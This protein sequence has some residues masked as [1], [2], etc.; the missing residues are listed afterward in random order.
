MSKWMESVCLSL[1]VALAAPAFA[2]DAAA[3]APA[4]AAAPA[5]GGGPAA[6]AGTE[7]IIVT[8]SYIKGTPKDTALPVDVKSATQLKELNNPSIAETVRNLGYTSGNIAEENQFGSSGGSSQGAEGIYNINLRGLGGARTLVLINGKRQV[9]TRDLG[10][11]LGLLPSGAVDRIEVLKDG[12]AATYGSDAI[13]GV[14]NFIT[15][16][17]FEGFEIGGS[18]QFVQDSSG[19]H[20]ASMTFGHGADNWNY[21]V[22]GEWAHRSELK[23]ADRNWGLQP[24]DKNPEGGWSGFGNPAGFFRA[25]APGTGGLLGG[26]QADPNCNELGGQETGVGVG[27]AGVCRFQYTRFDN[28]TNNEDDWRT[29]GEFNYTLSDNAE[30][31]TEVAWSK[32]NLEDI[33][34]SPSYAPQSFFGPDRFLTGVPVVVSGVTLQPNPALVDFRTRYPALFPTVGPFTPDTQ[35]VDVVNRAAGV[36]GWFGKAQ[37]GP[38]ENK[39]IRVGTDL[40]GSIADNIDYSIGVTYSSFD[41]SGSTPDTFVERMALALDGFGGPNCQHVLASQGINGCHFYNPFS[42]AVQH[43]IANNA[44]N[45]TCTGPADVNCFNPAVANDA[46]MMRWLIGRQHAQ[47]ETKLLA[48]DGV[49][50]GETPYDLGAGP[51][52]WA[53][54]F[55]ARKEEYQSNFNDVTDLAKT[56]CPFNDEFSVTLGNISQAN[57]DACHNGTSFGAGPFGFLAGSFEQRTQRTVYA[58]FGESHVP[59]TDKIDAQLAARFEDYGSDT[60]ST[61]DPKLAVSYQV[62]DWLKLRGTVGTTFRGPPQY[63]LGGSETALVFLAPTLAFKAVQILGN[64]DLKPETALTANF[65]FVV[66]TG[67]LFATVDWWRYAFQDPFQI[68][69]PNQ[70]VDQYVGQACADGQAGAGTANCQELRSHVFPTGTPAALLDRV[71]VNYINGSDITTSGIDYTAQY[72]FD[73]ILGGQ[74]SFGSE[75]TYTLE[76]QSKDLNDIGG[77]KVAEGKDFNNS[78]NDGTPFTP[79]PGFKGNAFAKY[80]HGIVTGTLVFRYVKSY[81]DKIPAPTIAQGGFSIRDQS[82]VD[83]FQTWD[84][85]LLFSLFNDSTTLTLSAINLLDEDPPQASVD[86]NYDSFTADGRGRLLKIGFLYRMQPGH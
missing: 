33:K 15:R 20:D 13:G 81:E 38:A 41:R 63:Y 61:F 4:P 74:L 50:S 30:W 53:A 72:T 36:A 85:H 28:I 60:G 75:G 40:T 25:F 62:L 49:L 48:W 12:A 32:T 39:T 7:T 14:V 77:V 29:Y 79:F 52:G 26:E 82:T 22:A 56:P 76:Y 6:P 86:L 80:A 55:Q 54:G 17:G 34:T 9:T 65:G 37:Q 23:I 78:L 2:D 64:P 84:F 18:E 21:F 46:D 11:D 3:P 19:D 70:I 68:E 45:P 57:F 67:G 51:I 69:S 73:D 8:G 16:K 35:G 42:T 58:F 31:H 27:G 5:A 66:E 59:I 43:S 47:A 83:S 10:V 44:D 1:A 71:D 24:F